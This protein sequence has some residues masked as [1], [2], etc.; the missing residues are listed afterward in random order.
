MTADEG[1]ILDGGQTVLRGVVRGKEGRLVHGGK[2]GTLEWLPGKSLGL[3]A[4]C[5]PEVALGPIPHFYPFIV[6]NPGEMIP[7]NRRFAVLWMERRALASAF[8]ME[9]GFNDTMHVAFTGLF[10]VFVVV[11]IVLSAIAYPGWFRRFSIIMLVVLAGFGAASAVAIQG[12]EQNATAWA[13]GFER[14]NAYTYFAWIVVLAAPKSDAEV[15]QEMRDRLEIEDLMWRYARALDTNNADAY[16]A[17]YTPDGS[18]GTGAVCFPCS[19]VPWTP[20]NSRN[21]ASVSLPRS[22][23]RSTS[24]R[25]PLKRNHGS[26]GVFLCGFIPFNFFS[27]AVG[28]SMGQVQNGAGLDADEVA[29]TAIDA[30]SGAK[31]WHPNSQV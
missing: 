14:I 20:V 25:V 15:I 12:I 27:I 3:S 26:T 13:G 31:K 10:T 8:D 22:S 21:S 6:N 17:I 5:Y 7:D 28:V 19:P 4:S 1:Q 11:A 24:G 16:A 18:F 23:G 9:G 2:H 30:G 29:L